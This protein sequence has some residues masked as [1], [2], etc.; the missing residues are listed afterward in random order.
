VWPAQRAQ[1]LST[2]YGPSRRATLPALCST[3]AASI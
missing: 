2:G 3:P 1:Q